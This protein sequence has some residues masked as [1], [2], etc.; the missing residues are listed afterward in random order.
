MPDPAL[1]EANEI[2][3]RI[4]ENEELHDLELDGFIRGTRAGKTI[5]VTLDVLKNSLRKQVGDWESALVDY[6]LGNAT[7]DDLKRCIVDIRNVAG[8]IFLKV[9]ETKEGPNIA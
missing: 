7:L 3:R 5:S 6:I 9:C 1:H 2:L 8:C 4:N